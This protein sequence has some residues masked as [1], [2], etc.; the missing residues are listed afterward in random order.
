MTTPA[1]SAEADQAATAYHVALTQIGVATVEDALSLWQG[2]PPARTAATSAAWL[3]RAIFLVMT[4]RSRARDL[5]M[6]Y[7][8][9]A[10]ALRTG[11]TVA[12]PCRPGPAY[13]SLD[14]LRRE[15]AALAGPEQPTSAAVTPGTDA[16]PPTTEADQTGPLPDDEEADEGSDVDEADRILV[17]EI[18]AIDREQERQERAAEEETRIALQELGPNNLDRK[19]ADIDTTAPA[20]TV[21]ALREDA[22]RRAGTRQAAAA[23]RIVMNGARGTAWSLGQRDRRVVGYVRLSQSGTP[24]GWC[25]MLISRGA[26]YKSQRSAEYADGDK[27]HDNC[28]CTAEQVFTRDQFTGSDLFALNRRY[29]VL[30]PQ[31]T[32]GLS[33]KAALRAWRRF[34]RQEQAAA[35]QARRSSNVQEA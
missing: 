29:G 3:R 35:Q 34:I 8:R 25:A 15:F 14:M 18:E 6:A 26:V 27:Y 4:R 7:Y 2:V 5:A 32:K 11:R 1:R 28:H 12:N 30:W 20:A 16:A 23:E 22:H 31:V 33:G 17:E 9:L 10:R 19:L 21:D 13:V 24:C